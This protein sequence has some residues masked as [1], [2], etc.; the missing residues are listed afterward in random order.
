[1]AKVTIYTT[2]FCPFCVRAKQLLGS[3]GVDFEEI[4]VDGRND[5][6][7]DLLARTGQRTVPQIWVGDTHV[8]GCDELMTLER[9]AQ[10]DE[11]LAS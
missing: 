6:R 3:K 10:L 8:G 5:L 9:Q 11:M 2:R 4:P 7:K 1:M